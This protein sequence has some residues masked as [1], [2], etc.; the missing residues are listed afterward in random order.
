[1]LSRSLHS[2]VLAIAGSTMISS[3]VAAQSAAALTGAVATDGGLP[4]ADVAVTLVNSSSGF[5]TRVRTNERGQYNIRQ[6][7]LGGPYRVRAERIGYRPSQRDD[8]QFVLGDRLRLDFALV[9]LTTTLSE[10]VVRA[11]AAT[12]T[13]GRF[14]AAT[15][16]RGEAIDALPT[17]ARDFTDLASLDPTFVRTGGRDLSIG[18][19][20]GTQTEFLIDGMSTRRSLSGG[21]SG[22]GAYTMSMAAIREFEVTRNE[23]DVTYGRSGG[24]V[25]VVTKSG[26]ND[27]TGELFSFHRNEQLTTRDYIGREPEAFTLTQVGFAAGGPIVRDRLHYFVAYDQQLE[28][29]P[30]LNGDI[31]TAEDEIAFGVNRDSLTRMFDILESKYGL[32][33][34]DGQFGQFTR[35]PTNRAL[36]GRLDW[37]IAANHALTVRSNLTN[38][39][40]PRYRGGNLALTLIEAKEGSRSTELSAHASLRSTFS[41]AWTNEARI[42]VV[43]LA[44]FNEPNTD[45]PRGFVR[46]QSRLPNGTP[47]DTRVQFGGNAL[48]PSQHRET[49]LQFTNTSYLQVGRQLLTFGTD[50]LFT[51]SRSQES[52]NQGGLFEFNSL[53]ELDAQ[54]P[55][56]YSRQAPLRDRLNFATPRALW[57]GLFAQTDYAISPALAV[58]AGLRW[59]A[60]MFFNTPERNPAAEQAFGIRTDRFAKFDPIGG[61][62]PRLQVT[63]DA[64]QDGSRVLVIGGGAFRSQTLN[65]TTVNAFL[66][67]GNQFADITVQGTNVPTPDYLT[68]RTDQSTVP[69]IEAAGS[70]QVAPAFLNVFSED[71]RLPMIWKGNV[72]YRQQVGP[73]SL[74]ANFLL[75]RT[76]R[77]YAY[78]DR[79]LKTT[80]D[81][82]LPDGRGVL[83][84]SA[85]MPT[86]G[87]PNTNNARINQAFGRVFE[88][89]DAGEATNRAMV[90]DAMLPLRGTGS[91]SASYTLNESRDN[92]SFNCCN[93]VISTP[94]VDDHRGI[95]GQLSASDYDFR[96]K[97]VG[98]VQLPETWGFRVSA[99]YEGQAGTPFSL[100][101]GSDINGDG[102]ANNDLSFVPDPDNP[103]TP[104]PVAAAMRRVLSNPN[105]LARD[106]IQDHL[107]GVAPRNG[108]RNPW[109]H[110]LDVRASRF[111]GTVR[112]QRIEIVGDVFNLPSLLNRKWG[113]Q[114]SLGLRQTLLNVTGFDR[115][116]QQYIYT[117]NE[118]VGVTQLSGTPY[119]I[120]LGA[121]YHF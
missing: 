67:T 47:G 13:A 52:N 28:S 121:R 116:Q 75:S 14:S 23:Y 24:G 69:G 6:I 106:Y 119:Q 73:V 95:E 102:Q 31:R 53:A 77:N 82:R 68:Y 8:V 113:G 79:N 83:V 86:N 56:R 55:F 81:F 32:A 18:G 92:L 78:Y 87:R 19:Q 12:Q 76:V 11:D 59:D 104:A 30:F 44:R 58:Q 100:V 42:Q 115:V 96:H 105:N 35:R 91:I 80:P 72:S 112:G 41:S 85:T 48:S 97:F 57:T 25:N 90:L 109:L 5:T 88:L 103:N 117:V 3:A 101:T 71:Y 7:P 89:V 36:F 38:W 17:A 51:L 37:N 1:M 66:G 2:A 10:L 20:R 39:N 98:V 94:V 65:W 110:R 120:Q 33:S 74:G 29:T 21:T 22:Q 16:I 46:I 93:P 61:L 50:N 34:R 40:D 99:R 108:G 26:T 49:Q 62:Q 63:W 107:G 84:P 54:R 45:I 43:R 15:S 70:A 27:F 60:Q 111:F 64:K 114:R 4:L 9:Q 118:N